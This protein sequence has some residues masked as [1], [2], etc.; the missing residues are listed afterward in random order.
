[1]NHKVENFDNQFQELTKG[2]LELCFEYVNF[3]S[4]NIDGIYIYCS[5]EMD[6][7][8]FNVFYNVNGQICKKHEVGTDY[9]TSFGTQKSLN[10]NGNKIMT[11]IVELFKNDKREIPTEI[12]I[13]YLVK[14][15]KF[16]CDIKYEIFW[17]H[18]PD[19]Y[20]NMICEQWG[21]EIKNN[22]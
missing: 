12:K 14:S 10:E 2:V 20:P 13:S 7:I 17:S 19:G 9:D 8:T 11:S 21:E 22:L 6:T 3:D 5:T 18:L 15:E 16:N 1:M 4:K